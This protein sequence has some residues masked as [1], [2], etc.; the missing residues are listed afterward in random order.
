MRSSGDK[1]SFLKNRDNLTLLKPIH[2]GDRID[3]ETELKT[4]KA[5]HLRE[6]FQEI[7]KEL[8]KRV[9]KK[10]SKMVFL[11]D[12][13]QDKPMKAAAKTIRAHWAGVLRWNTSKSQ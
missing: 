10:P 4:V 8:Q 9:L 11:G 3:A 12:T 13:Q 7:Y 2:Y 5:Y 6:N 1:G